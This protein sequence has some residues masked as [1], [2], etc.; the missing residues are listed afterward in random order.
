MKPKS[1]EWLEQQLGFEVNVPDASQTLEH[2]REMF[3]GFDFQEVVIFGAGS[4]GQRM[5]DIL[6]SKGI[7]TRYF[8]D[9]FS[10]GELANKPIYHP[11]QVPTDELPM[12]LASSWFVEV[13]ADLKLHY[14][15]IC[16]RQ[17]YILPDTSFL[18]TNIYDDMVGYCFFNTF[19]RRYQ[20]YK[21][22]CDLL[23]EQ[24][25]VE[26]YCKVLAY[27]LGF[28]CPEKVL[29]E[30]LPIT[31]EEYAK[32]A[33]PIPDMPASF[34][35][36]LRRATEQTFAYPHYQ[37]DG[38]A[39]PSRG[40][41]VF[42]CGAWEGDTSYWYASLIGQEGTVYAF[43]PSPHSHRLMQEQL[44]PC[45]N[46]AK[47]I[48]EPYAVGKQVE[49]Q[50]W[51]DIPEAGTCSRFSEIATKQKVNVTSIDEYVLRNNVKKIDVIKTDLEG[52][53]FDALLGSQ[54]TIAQFKP[55]LCISIYHTADH[56]VDIPLWINENFPE[57]KIRINHNHMGVN[58]SI[59][60]ATVK[61]RL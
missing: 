12:I 61:N 4:G 27:R 28:F 29:P 9:N 38:F 48:S 23:E 40:D 60:I 10:S 53:D 39:G 41:V 1:I 35:A 58:E 52:A 8:I 50:Y 37:I 2:M 13:Y 36:P 42:D 59:C 18:T 51:D 3:N 24:A 56:L 19:D 57:Y 34:K 14:P 7:T 33:K 31:S 25:S 16:T 43:E 45:S 55:D 46:I 20:D 15:K 26:Q 22:V 17:V 32:K 44:S 54:N 49:T 5:H 6:L 11:K 30:N 47:I 21:Q